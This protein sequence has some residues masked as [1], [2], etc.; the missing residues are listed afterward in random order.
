M[1]EAVREG[2]RARGMVRVR[3]GRI[4][5]YRGGGERRRRGDE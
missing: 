3:D 2:W 5:R 1:L 4:G